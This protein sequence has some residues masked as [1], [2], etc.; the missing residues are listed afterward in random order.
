MSERGAGSAGRDSARGAAGDGGGAGGLTVLAGPGSRD[1]SGESASGAGDP[2]DGLTVV[3]RKA[4]AWGGDDATVLGTLVGEEGKMGGISS[5]G[6]GGASATGEAGSKRE[7]RR[8]WMPGA[9]D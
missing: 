1:C 5:S 8:G 6:R 2:G 7:R 9:A 4:E 3:V